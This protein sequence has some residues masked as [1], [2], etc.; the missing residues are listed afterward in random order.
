MR[1]TRR[2]RPARPGG[3]VRI[4]DGP[5][6][7]RSE[8]ARLSGYVYVDIR[9]RDLGGYVAPT[10]QA[11]GGERQLPPGYYVTWSGQF[12]YLERA[13]DAEA[14]RAADAA[15]HLRAA[16]PELPPPDEA[17]IV[18]L[19]VPFALVG[20][21]WLLWAARLQPERRGGGRLHRAGRRGG[22]D[23]RRDADLPRPRLGEASAEVPRRGPRPPWRSCAT[24]RDGRA[25]SSACGRR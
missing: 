20:G 6:V 22:R 15:D 18:M 2:A 8:N 14:R 25:R 9:G 21:V 10:Q 19:S 24:P 1:P 11:R 23:R 3:R 4:A 13:V 7:I 17:L 16:V 12:E 5:P